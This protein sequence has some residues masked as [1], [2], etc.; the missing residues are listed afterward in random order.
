MPLTTA[1]QSLNPAQNHFLA[2]LSKKDRQALIS[3]GEVV[4]LKLKRRLYLGGRTADCIYFP[5][6]CVVSIMVGSEG[7][8]LEMATIGREGVVGTPAILND[9]RT[10]GTAVVQREGKAM[11]LDLKVFERA[12]ARRPGVDHLM[13]RFLHALIFQIMQSG[14]CHHLHTVQERCARWLLLMHAA[15]ESPTFLLT[16]EFLSEMICVRR[17]S[18][19]LAVGAFRKAGYIQ[20]ARGK[21]TILNQNGLESASCD[22]YQLIRDEYDRLDDLSSREGL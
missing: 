15:A 2:T 21:V 17:A 1:R 12:V 13:K 19:N 10:I 6:D 11:R 3:Q 16:Q 18:V 4:D 5:I 9:G 22:C 14:A 20:Y 8:L 7:S